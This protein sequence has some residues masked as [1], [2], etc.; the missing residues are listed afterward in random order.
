MEPRSKASNDQIKNGRVSERSDVFNAG[1]MN[2]KIKNPHKGEESAHDN[3]KQTLKV[4]EIPSSGPSKTRGGVSTSTS[5][6]LWGGR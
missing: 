6:K 5:A 4:A 3:Q 1:R 2:R